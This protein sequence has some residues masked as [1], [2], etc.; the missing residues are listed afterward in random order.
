[1]GLLTSFRV[2]CPYGGQVE[3]DWLPLAIEINTASVLSSP[4][5]LEYRDVGRY[6]PGGDP[7]MCY[8]SSLPIGLSN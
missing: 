2:S 1:M 8:P 6:I 7:V 5:S 3:A 4:C